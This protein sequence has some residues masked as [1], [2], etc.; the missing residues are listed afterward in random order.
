MNLYLRKIMPLLMERLQTRKVT[1][2]TGSRQ[3]GK[4]TLVR[5]LL[6]QASNFNIVYHNLDDPD[7]R[8]RLAEN[9]VARLDSPESLIVIDEIQ[10]QPSLLDVVKLLVDRPDGP[11]FFLLG[12]SQILLLK[13]VRESLAGR[14]TLLNLWPLAVAERV[15]TNTEE[16]LLIDR[17]FDNGEAAIKRQSASP[18]SVDVSRALR[19]S[20]DYILRW[21]GYPPVETLESDAARRTWL[22]DYRNTY[23]ERD[24]AD[25]GRV[26][27]L[28]QFARAQSILAAR[29]GQILSY[30]EVARDLG[31][32][33]NTVHRYVRFLE[34]SY[35]VYLLRPFFPNITKRLVKS[36]KLYWLDAGLARLLSGRSDTSDGA[37]YESFIASELLKWL[38]WRE[39]PPNLGFYRTQAGAEV[40]FIIWNEDALIAMEVKASHNIHPGSVSNMSTLLEQ[41]AIAHKGKLQL[42]LV[43]Y[44]G[45]EIRQLRQNI[46][47][48][49][50][51][52]LFGATG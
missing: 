28:D 19:E 52:L 36:P 18:P 13:Q 29:T 10:K 42:G 47:A 34:I 41:N 24:L 25:I 4:T 8:L 39:D 6:P 12:S 43:V 15:P 3:T 30:S 22:R 45:T 32:A 46:W 50:D 23:L 35:Q 20:C 38:S 33:A 5:D 2:L 51:W 40:D 11:R 49:P 31:V 21:G 44:R 17:L 26:A 48:I 14:V 7:E 16:R 37:L 27:D 1:L 9:P